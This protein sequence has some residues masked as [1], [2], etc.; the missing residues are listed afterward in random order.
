MLDHMLFPLGNHFNR[1]K[2]IWG[3]KKNIIFPQHIELNIIGLVNPFEGPEEEV[4][5]WKTMAL[6]Q[7]HHT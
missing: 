7:K 3:V 4:T 1:I 2:K 5:G 6:I